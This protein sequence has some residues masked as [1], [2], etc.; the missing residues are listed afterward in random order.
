MERRK[1]NVS[2]ESILVMMLL[3]IFA[4]STCLM[5]IEGSESYRT[6]LKQKEIEENARIALSYINM[7]IKQND[8]QDHITIEKGLVEG[9]DVLTLMHSG[10]ETGYIT[11]L[12]WDEEY[13]WE[14]YTDVSTKPT[15]DLSERIVPIDNLNFSMDQEQNSVNIQIQY[16]YGKKQLTLNNLV[17]IRTSKGEV[18]Q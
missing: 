13:L 4:V 18:I 16:S 8:V 14:C 11:Y 15:K 17:A 12:F 9:R 2:F 3:I 6:I 7:R 1:M 5:I 10:E